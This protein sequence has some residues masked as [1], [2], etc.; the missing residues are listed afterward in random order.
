MLNQ[1]NSLYSQKY[2]VQSLNERY[3]GVLVYALFNDAAS[4]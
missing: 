3:L 1:I 2:C 4:S